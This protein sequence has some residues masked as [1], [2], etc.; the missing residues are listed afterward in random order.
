M[1]I[2]NRTGAGGAIAAEAVSRAAPDGNTLLIDS[3][4]FVIS[5][6][7]R[8]LS[9]DPLT[10]FEPI[11]YLT[12]TPSVIIVNNASPYLKLADLLDEARAKPG[13]L[14]LAAAGPLT[15]FHLGFEMRHGRPSRLQ[16]GSAASP[17]KPTTPGRAGIAPGPNAAVIAAAGH[18]CER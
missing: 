14:T 1:L 10:S 11:C 17:N 18:W 9:Y 12:S 3:N 16:T 5:P 13:E 8:K 6:Q 15:T 2:E 4:D 7:L